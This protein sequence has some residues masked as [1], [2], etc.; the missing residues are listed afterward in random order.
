MPTTATVSKTLSRLRFH[1]NDELTAESIKVLRT[2]TPALLIF[3]LG[4]R[5]SGK[6]SNEG[7]YEQR[8]HSRS[9]IQ[10]Y[11]LVLCSIHCYI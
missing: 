7:L 3:R 1:L 5:I 6:L 9:G 11:I 10:I 4:L 8:S 2:P